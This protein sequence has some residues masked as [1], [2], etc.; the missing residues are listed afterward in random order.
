VQAIVEITRDPD[1]DEPRALN[2][3]TLMSTP[4]ATGMTRLQTHYVLWQ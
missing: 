1:L 4:D 2:E 3:A